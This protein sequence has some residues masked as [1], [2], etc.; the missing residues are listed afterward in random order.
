MSS[1]CRSRLGTSLAEPEIRASAS[2]KPSAIQPALTFAKGL[3]DLPISYW[4]P[5]AITGFTGYQIAERAPRP[6]MVNAGFS[7]QY[8]IPYLVSKV[9]RVDLPSF[10]L[11]MTPITEVVF[12]VPAGRSHGQ[13][14]MILV[15]PGIS[16]SE[17]K[18]WELAIEAMI[19]ATKVTG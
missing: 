13:H 14:T 16:Y 17:G 19:P 10:L 18:G 1:C 8:S 5:L 12:N 15:A 4:R 11:G 6:N 2:P 3:G 9:A 7:V